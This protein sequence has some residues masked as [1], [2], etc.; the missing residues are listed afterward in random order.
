M[1]FPLTARVE[2]GQRIVE[3]YRTDINPNPY[4]SK[5]VNLVVRSAMS[6]RRS[7]TV[8][9]RYFVIKIQKIP[10]YVTKAGVIKYAKLRI[11]ERRL[12]PLPENAFSYLSEKST[13]AI[14]RVTK[15]QRSGSKGLIRTTTSGPLTG[16]AFDYRYEF[17]KGLSAARLTAL[18]AKA[19]TKLLLSAKDQKVNLVQAYA[20]RSQTA[21]LIGDTATAIAGMLVNLKKGRIRE[22]ASCVGLTVSKRRQARIRKHWIDNQY[23]VDQRMSN[24]VLQLQYGW[25]PLLQDIYGSAELLAQKKMREV[26]NTVRSRSRDTESSQSQVTVFGGVGTLT[27]KNRIYREVSFRAHFATSSDMVHTL[28]QVGLTNPAL[29]AWELTPWSFVIDW[30]LP[31]GNYISSLDATL[32]LTFLGGSRTVFTREICECTASYSG[33]MDRSTSSEYIGYSVSA[34]ERVTTD[35]TVLSAWPSPQLPAFKNPVSFEHAINGVAL[36][37]GLKTK[38]VK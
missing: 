22:A 4:S 33:K 31:V 26:R 21:R 14:G 32:G 24:G 29:I 38:L 12:V 5:T 34:G 37:L 25:R 27:F 15:I 11:K 2:Q 6:E 36:L 35:R 30:F 17:G 13:V 20:E 9:P 19:Q 7:G 16:S 10:K 18:A 23:S 3:T 28:S 8:S 1:Y